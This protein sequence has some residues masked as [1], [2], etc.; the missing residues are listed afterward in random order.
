M[1]VETMVE[2]KNNIIVSSE[3]NYIFNKLTKKIYL[4]KLIIF[5]KVRNLYNR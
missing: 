1:R 4:T 3:G 2:E 5:L